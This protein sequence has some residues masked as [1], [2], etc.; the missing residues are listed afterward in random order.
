M[1][2]P[3][4]STYIISIYTFLCGFMLNLLAVWGFYPLISGVG[5]QFM[6]YIFF[7][8]NVSLLCVSQIEVGVLCGCC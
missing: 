1:L 5:L 4:Y 2:W 7:C 3:D 8:I 6:F